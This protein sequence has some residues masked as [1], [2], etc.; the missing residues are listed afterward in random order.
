MTDAIPQSGTQSG[1]DQASA[2]SSEAPAGAALGFTTLGQLVRNFLESAAGGDGHPPADILLVAAPWQVRMIES[3]INAKPI[4]AASDIDFPIRVLGKPIAGVMSGWTVTRMRRP[5]VIAGRS[6]HGAFFDEW[7]DELVD[8]LDDLWP[9]SPDGEPGDILSNDG[10][11][12]LPRHAR[13]TSTTALTGLAVEDP[14]RAAEARP[15]PGGVAPPREKAAGGIDRYL[16]DVAVRDQ[17]A[18]LHAL[19]RTAG[20]ARR[21]AWKSP[22]DSKET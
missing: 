12:P 22:Y 20:P 1:F 9:R 11:P 18:A 14:L 5:D 6:V 13:L 17:R 15:V 4:H 19:L 2:C 7:V 16:D 10:A 3:M 21:Q 8:A